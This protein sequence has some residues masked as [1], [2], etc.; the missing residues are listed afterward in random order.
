MKRLRVRHGESH[1]SITIELK[2][3]Y[4]G[5]AVVL[6]LLLLLSVA[7]L[8]WKLFKRCSS[9]KRNHA[10]NDDLPTY[11]RN[12]HLTSNF[13]SSSSCGRSFLF[14]QSSVSV[15]VSEMETSDEKCAH[16]EESEVPDPPPRTSRFV[17]KRA[18]LQP[19]HDSFKTQIIPPKRSSE[20]S[21]LVHIVNLKI[22]PAT[23]SP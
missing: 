12:T 20:P 2:V 8:T 3:L 1:V 9:R 15:F 10:V 11:S 23:L 13:I 14:R 17:E 19:K 6:A 21:N 5:C 22:L 18:S 16:E 4:I 7:F